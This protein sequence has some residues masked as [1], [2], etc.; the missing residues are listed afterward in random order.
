MANPAG[1]PRSKRIGI[2]VDI[3]KNL[4][5]EKQREDGFDDKVALNIPAMPFGAGTDP[6]AAVLSHF[7]KKMALYPEAQTKAQEGIPHAATK[8][9]DYTGK[10]I[11]KDTMIYPNLVALSRDPE[12]YAQPNHF[13][14]DRFK[15]DTLSAAE[16]A[17]HEDYKQQDHPHFGFGHRLCPGIHVVESSLFMVIARLLWAYHIKPRPGNPLDM[18]ISDVLSR[19]SELTVVVRLTGLF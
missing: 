17:V 12:L 6:T 5:K 16:S 2:H 7:F 1:T 19:L 3:L 8:D 9:D 10:Q 4:R 14:P 18:K 11:R 13:C 15:G